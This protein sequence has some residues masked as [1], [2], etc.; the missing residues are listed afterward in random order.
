MQYIDIRA[1]NIIPG[2]VL[3][4][5]E[6]LTI[7]VGT[8]RDMNEETV[9]VSSRA[10]APR[11]GQYKYVEAVGLH[12]CDTVRLV[13]FVSDYPFESDDAGTD[14][15]D[16]YVKGSTESQ[17]VEMFEPR[18][19][20]DRAAAEAKAD[21]VHIHEIMDDVRRNMMQGELAPF[22]EDK[23][24]LLDVAEAAGVVKES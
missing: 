7:V 20:E 18:S 16:N 5:D 9:T 10:F 14:F 23:D 19:W 8:I 24:D 4:A 15:C 12:F 11:P 17:I 21:T 13:G 6:E 2:M 1:F 3:V 22:H